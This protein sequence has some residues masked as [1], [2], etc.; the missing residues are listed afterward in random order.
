MIQRKLSPGF[1][2]IEA[3]AGMAI[4]LITF[5]ASLAVFNMVAN[6]QSANEA[7]LGFVSARNQL[8]SL[9]IDDT[10]WQNMIDAPG[11]VDNPKFNC[12][13]KQNSVAAGERDCFGQTD[14]LVIYNIKGD[15]YVMNGIN[16]YDF[17][18]ATQGFSQKGLA[19]NTFVAPPAAGD[20]LCPYQ[21]VVTWSAVCEASPCTNPPIVFRGLTTF[22]G[23][24]NQPIPNT[25]NLNFQLIKSVLYCPPPI[26]APGGHVTGDPNVD[27][28]AIDRVRS[29][30]FADVPFAE[31]GMTD[32]VMAPCRRVSVQFQEDM[33]TVFTANANNTSSVYIRNESTGTDV[34][35]FRRLG[36]GAGY[37]YQLYADGAVVVNTKPTWQ[38]ISN[39]SV[40]KFDIINGLVRFCVDERCTHYFSRKLDF[41]FRFVYKPASAFHTP[42]GINNINYTVL[43]F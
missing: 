1:T 37:D 17:R 9:L 16:A 22:N 39:A 7:S 24:P 19:C 27:V 43:D 8:V 3:L 35:E 42:G 30:T 36:N 31:T 4:L 15:K 11:S 6:G 5:L 2:I 18:V 25:R 21:M 14:P 34:F 10:S 23:G 41:P 13:L 29:T 28:S 12:L 32:I 26:V 40:F 38:I 33:N 20:P